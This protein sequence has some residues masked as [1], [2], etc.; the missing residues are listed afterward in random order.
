MQ[1]RSAK[2]PPRVYSFELDVA[3]WINSSKSG[4]WLL[5]QPKGSWMVKADVEENKVGCCVRSSWL[6]S[7]WLSCSISS[8]IMK[9]VDGSVL[10][11]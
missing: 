1:A 6:L 8:S 9:K 7:S 3:S 4:E 11:F 2:S 10:R 5:Q